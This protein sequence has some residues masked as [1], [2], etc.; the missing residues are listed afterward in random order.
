MGKQ[1]I[2]DEENAVTPVFGA[3]LMVFLTFVLAVATVTAVYDDGA[4]ERIN[5]LLT[6]TPAAVIEIEGIE[7]GAI[8]PV[9]YHTINTIL[10]HKGGDSLLLDSTIIILS[11]GGRSYIGFVGHGGGMKTGDMTVKYSDLT[12]NGKLPEYNITNSAMLDDNLWSTGE[13][14]ILNGG[15]SINGTDASSVL[16]SVN[17]VSN[18]SNNY[19]FDTG[20][21]V[22]IKIFDKTT[23]RIIAE[24]KAIVKSAE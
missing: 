5:N 11:G 8:N 23:Q 3:L 18:T 2:K 10:R 7:N 21:T 4:V 20:T 15:D 12:M 13:Q 24:G 19:G 1:A 22:T 16:V 9:P 17:G 14:L 6:K